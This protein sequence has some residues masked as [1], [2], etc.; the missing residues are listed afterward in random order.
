MPQHSIL[1]LQSGAHRRGAFRDFHPIPIPNPISDDVGDDDGDDDVGD[2]GDD[3]GDGVQQKD[4]VELTLILDRR[5]CG[6]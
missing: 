2:A 1:A 3:D 4:I 5:E 6:S